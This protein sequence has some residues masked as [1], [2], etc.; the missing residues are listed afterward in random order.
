MKKDITTFTR[1]LL[2]LIIVFVVWLI[3]LHKSRNDDSFS[4]F[5]GKSK[6]PNSLYICEKIC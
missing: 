2:L 1:Y 4:T 3:I 6:K 5:F